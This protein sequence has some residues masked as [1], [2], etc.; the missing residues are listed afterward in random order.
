M[1]QQKIRVGIIG[2]GGNFRDRHIPGFKALKNVELAGVAN[3]SRESSERAAKEFGI[4]EVYDSWLDLMESDDIDAIA[5][6]TWPYMH[7]PLVLAALENNKHVL[8]EARMA[9]NAQEARTMLDASR[10]SPHL[11]TM[12]V[13]GP[14]TLSID[15]MIFRL[16]ESGYLGDVL[17]VE[18]NLAG[19]SFVDRNAP[20]AWRHDAALSGYNILNMGIWSEIL[21]RWLGPANKVMAMTK[22]AVK[23]RKDATGRFRAVTVPDH[24]DILADMACGAQAHLR[25]SAVTGLGPSNEVWLFGSE[26]TLRIDTQALKIYGGKRGEKELAPIPVAEELIVKSVAPGLPPGWRVEEEF[27][28]AILGKEPVRN[29][30]FEDGVRYMEFTEAVSRSAQEGKAISLPL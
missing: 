4:A 13:P 23:Q 10:I 19:R 22:T 27:I 30:T 1:N 14:M 2:A 20:L 21:M 25:F 17:S 28:N 9:L 12:I 5:I 7:C 18:L 15:P 26:G 24:V 3:R 11:V 29:T 6:G 8:T 16:L